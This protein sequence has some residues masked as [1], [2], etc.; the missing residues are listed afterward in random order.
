MAVAIVMDFPG[1]TLD[2]YDA[3][4]QSMGLV[5]GGPPPEGAISHFVTRT[6]DGIRV[7]DVWETQEQFDKFAREQI[8]P[9]TQKAGIPGPPVMTVYEVH[10]HFV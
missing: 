5:P 6:D 9:Q 4:I 2:Q 10:N 8:G 1:A 3:V 7:V